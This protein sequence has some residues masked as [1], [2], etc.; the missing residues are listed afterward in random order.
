MTFVECE[1]G[2]DV[3][4]V[5]LAFVRLIKKVNDDAVLI[6]DNEKRVTCKYYSFDELKRLLE[7]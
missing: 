2:G 7:E 3:Y 6:C 1:S 5:N 4:L